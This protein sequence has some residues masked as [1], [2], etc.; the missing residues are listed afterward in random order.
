[1]RLGA[2]AL[3]TVFLRLRSVLWVG[4]F[5]SALLL[6]SAALYQA[7]VSGQEAIVLVGSGSSVPAPL[8]T[9]LAEEYNRRNPAIQM[10]Y[11]PIGTSEGIKQIS[12]GSGDFGAG[13][14]P[15]TASERAE[16]NLSEFPMVLIGIVPYYNVPGV[17]QDLRFTGELLAD[18]LLG[19]VKNWKDPQIAKLNPE[20]SLP[21]LPIKIVYRPAGKGTNYVFTEFLSKTSVKFRAR[22]GVSASPKWPV[23]T[24]AER[25]ADMVDKV[26]AETGAFGYGEMQYAVKENVAYGR[27]VNPAGKYVKASSE[28]ILAACRAVEAPGWDKMAASLTNAPG[29]ESYPVTSFTWLY[30][31][32][33]SGDS[34]RAGA[35][36]DLLSW[37]FT[38][39][40]QLAKNQGYTELPPQLLA[41]VR[42]KANSLH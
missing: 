37:M 7:K 20:G 3:S 22:I 21:D 8:Y 31:R 10:R 34:R 4:G 28:T 27:V 6:L 23:G 38:D 18:I 30:L 39:G 33:S 29:E 17:H 24:P 16:A 12:H 11:L 19:E 13:E 14:V 42:E 36:R 41:K 15:L 2:Q 26:K 25:S 5:A 40:E 9:K 32:N 35:V 1:M